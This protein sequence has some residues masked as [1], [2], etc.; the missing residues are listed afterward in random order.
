MEYSLL[1]PTGV[2]VSSI[3]LGTATFG[4]SRTERDADRMNHAALDLGIN[5]LDTANVYGN[6]PVF[7]RPSVLPAA[8]CQPAEQIWAA[9]AEAGLNETPQSAFSPWAW[10]FCQ[11]HS[12]ALPG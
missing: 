6:T 10:S 5:F 4:V 11:Y 8:E 12:P 3:C 9:R 7:D 1:G 2:K